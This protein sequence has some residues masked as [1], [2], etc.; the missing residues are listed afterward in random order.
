MKY[1][2]SNIPSYQ[3]ILGERFRIHVRFEILLALE[4]MAYANFVSLFLIPQFDLNYTHLLPM[5]AVTRR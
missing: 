5:R 2:V 3:H 4:N 1:E